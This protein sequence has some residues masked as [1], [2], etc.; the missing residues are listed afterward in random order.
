MTRQI[1]HL[2]PLAALALSACA[3][4]GTI[5]TGDEVAPAAPIATSP[6]TVFGLGAD[7]LPQVTLTGPALDLD[8]SNRYRA[9]V[10]Y[11]N[12]TPMPIP[13]Y[14]GPDG[15]DRIGRLA[16]GNG[17]FLDACTVPLEVDACSITFGETRARGWVLMEAMGPYAGPPAES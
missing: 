16:P 12:V 2:L 6:S 10:A 14:S 11:V 17:G 15:Q 8:W 7:D 3:G 9:D 1:R 13:V 4:T 5:E